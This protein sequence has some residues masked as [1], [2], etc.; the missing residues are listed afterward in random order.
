MDLTSIREEIKMIENSIIRD[1]A[2]LE[3]ATE[4]NSRVL[5][6]EERYREAVKFQEELR[7]YNSKLTRL[8][9]Y[10]NKKSSTYTDERK[11]V[12]EKIV[13]ENLLYIFPEERFKAQLSLDVS[14][15][16]RETCQLLIGVPSGSGVSYAATTAQNGRFVRQLVSLV[17]VYSLNYLRGSDTLFIDEALASSDKDN[18]TK[19]KPLLDRITESGIQIILIEHKPELYNGV[20]RRQFDLSKNRKTGET[21][22]VKVTD[23]KG[24]NI[25]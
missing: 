7:E 11:Q 1:K 9:T 14:R 10:C 8:F 18:L 6:F 17:V 16:G 21:T 13:E 2:K 25:E 12:I 23:V 15:K 4:S 22:I 5:K 20:D 3:T 19:L 24:D